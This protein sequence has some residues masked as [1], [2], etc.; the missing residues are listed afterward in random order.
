MAQVYCSEACRKLDRQPSRFHVCR[1]CA[2]EFE[3]TTP[4]Q[5]YCSE[6]CK[7]FYARGC[8]ETWRDRRPALVL[9]AQLPGE[10]LETIGARYGVSRQRICQI[11]EVLEIPPP[12]QIRRSGKHSL[13]LQMAAL[14]LTR[15]HPSRRTCC[16]CKE[17]K[18]L[19]EFSTD[20]ADGQGRARICLKCNSQRAGEYYYR[21]KL[22]RNAIARELA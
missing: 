1:T 22:E 11:F 19:T 6:E 8:S 21:K 9:Y 16:I 5:R 13:Q 7:P 20:P 12:Q 15:Y 2:K 17:N 14:N 18:E 3:W 4:N 10:S